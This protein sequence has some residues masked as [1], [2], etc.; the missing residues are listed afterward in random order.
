M[1]TAVRDM[2]LDLQ[3]LPEA[4]LE[5]AVKERL[6]GA[7]DA[8]TFAAFFAGIRAKRP[9]MIEDEVEDDEPDD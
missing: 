5:A 6:I 1:K 2:F 7:I 4:V 3:S 8:D 9:V